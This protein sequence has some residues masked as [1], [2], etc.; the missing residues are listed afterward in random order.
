MQVEDLLDHSLICELLN[1][2]RT[3]GKKLIGHL[4]FSFVDEIFKKLKTTNRS[5]PRDY[6]PSQDFKG[7]LYGL[8]EGETGIRGIA[9]KL[10][11]ITAKIACG[12]KKRTP[13]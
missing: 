2:V 3:R 9:R 6:S 8:A 4:D 10:R 12:F 11:E 5:R 13:I 7:I 1:F